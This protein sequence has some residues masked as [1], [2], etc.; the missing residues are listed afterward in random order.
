[1][2]IQDD[3]KILCIGTFNQYSGIS[4][5]NICRLN[6]DGTFDNTFTS[7]FNFVNISSLLWA[8]GNIKQLS[9]GKILVGGYFNYLGQIY[10]L[11]RL[12]SDGSVD[13]TFNKLTLSDTNNVGL[14]YFDL[15]NNGKILYNYGFATKRLD[16]DGN[17]D[18][19]FNTIS[20]NYVLGGSAFYNR[21]LYINESIKR[22]Y[23]GG[24]FSSV[25]NV[26]Y[27][28]F[29]VSDLDGNLEMCTPVI[30]PTP[31]ATPT[32][33]STPTLTPTQTPTS[34]ITPTLS[35]SVSAT[36]SET[37]T[38]SATPSETPTPSA[39]PT[40]TPSE[41]L[42]P[43]MSPTPSETPTPSITPTNSTTPTP[44]ETPTPSIT[45]TSTITPTSSIT[46]TPSITP[47]STITPTPS[48]TNTPSLT[49][50]SST[51]ATYTIGIYVSIQNTV[52]INDPLKTYYKIDSGSWTLLNDT[53]NSTVCTFVGN[54]TNIPNNS[55][56]YIGFEDT[57][58]VPVGFDATVGN[59]STCPGITGGADYCKGTSDWS[60]T[61]NSNGNRAFT[62]EAGGGEYLAC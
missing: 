60:D 15:Y 21:I 39:T 51:P 24:R 26:P 57:N 22:I 3:N 62:I 30:S 19:S 18:N 9:N 38:P 53:F 31:T 58:N 46:P 7:P 11:L 47:T 20:T 5:N 10:T 27:L 25:N 34:S 44:S 41:N 33:T 61:I 36:P 50:S 49:P 13:P 55:T 4:T 37:P 16:V 12:N 2:S 52:T 17:I 42:T 8:S 32:I 40:I 29:V 1:L 54:V 59:S 35:I 43:S 14:I 45:P 48:I 28:R 23:M 6:S 56:L